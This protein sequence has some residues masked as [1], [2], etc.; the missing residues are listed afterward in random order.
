VLVLTLL[1]AVPLGYAQKQ[2]AQSAIG[3]KSQP[4]ALVV[5]FSNGVDPLHP[6]VQLAS[7]LRTISSESPLQYRFL[8]PGKSQ[9]GL[10]RIILL[11]LSEGVDPVQAALRLHGIAAIEYAEPNYIYHIE[12]IP[13]K[14]DD[15]LYD[16]EWYLRN[17]HVPEAWQI[18]EGDS[19]VHIGFVDTG[20]DWLH[21]DLRNQFAIN[22]A[23]DINHNGYFDAWPSTE[24]RLDPRG[25]SVYGDLDGIDQ[26]GNGFADDVIGYDFVDQGTVNYGDA[27]HRDAIPQD[28]F[29]H[30]TAVAGVLAAEKNNKIGIAGVAPKCKLVAIRAFDFSGNAE[31][32]DV[33]AGIVYAADNH[34]NILNLSFGDPVPSLLQRDAISYATSKSVLVFAS[35]GNDGGDPRHY[36]SD[37]DEVVSVGG[38]TNSP[39]ED[40]V[41]SRTQFGEG[42]DLLAPA[43]N[44][45][46]TWPG[47]SYQVLA[48]TSFSSPIAAAVAGLLW[49][50]RPT[51]TPIELRSILSSATHDV[52]YPGYDHVAANGR[53]DALATLNYKGTAAIKITSPHTDDGFHIGDTIRIK[54]SALSSL[55]QSYSLS[56]GVGANPTR[57]G[58]NQLNDQSVWQSIDSSTNQVLT[59]SLGAWDTHGLKFGVYTLRLAVRSSD[60]RSTEE[61]LTITLADK[62]PTITLFSVDTV[63]L[64]EKRALQVRLTTNQESYLTLYYRPSADG[65]FASKTD[66]RYVHQHVIILTLQEADAGVPLTLQCVAKNLAG[67]SVSVSRDAMILQDMISQRGFAAKRYALPSGYALDSVLALPPGDQVVMSTFDVGNGAGPLKIFQ[68]DGV[69]GK[70][71]LADSGAPG[72]PRSIGNLKHD[73]K[74]NLL[75]Q[76]GQVATVYG[77]NASH[78]LLGD[79]VYQSDPQKYFFSAGL[80]DVDGDG[81]DVIIGVDSD[82]VLRAIKFVGSGFGLIGSLPNTSPPDPQHARNSYSVQSI[83]VGDFLQN[84]K[85]GVAIVDG[86]ADLAAYVRDAGQPAG[87]RQ[88][89]G[90]ENNG[91]EQWTTVS[92]GDFNGDGKIDL[93]FA[94]H[95]DP[96]HGGPFN[97]FEPDFCTLKVYLNQ[98]GGRFT[99]NT[100]ENFLP[101]RDPNSSIY[102]GSMRAIANVTGGKNKM[103]ALSIFP[104]FYLL[105]FDS[106][107][108]KMKAVWQ[109]PLSITTFGAIAH[110]FDRNGKTEFGF[111]AGDSIHFFERDDDYTDR[112]ATPG[113]LDV[114]PRSMSTV[115]L[116]WGVV[117][118]ATRYNVLRA[119]SGRTTFDLIATVTLP[120]FSDTKASNGKTYFYSV[121][122]LDSSKK[123]VE[124]LP[125]FSVLAYVHPTPVIKSV[126]DVHSGLRIKSSEPISQSYVSGGVIV[127]DDS[128]PCSSVIPELDTSM[129]A[130]PGKRLLPGSHH[131]RVTSFELCDAFNSPFDQA[132]IKFTIDTPQSFNTFFIVRWTF[133]NTT[134]IHVTF[135]HIPANDGLGTIHYAITPY[136]RITKIERDPND[137]LSL[138]IDLDPAQPIAPVGTPFVLCIEGVH[139]SQGDLLNK[140]GNCAGET[141]TNKD[142]QQI[143]VFPNPAKTSDDHLTFGGL[144]ATA[145]IT[146]FSE[147]MRVIRQI[148]TAE[149]NGG[150]QWDM[151]DANG[152]PLPSGIYL[153]AVTGMDDNGVTVSSKAAKFVIVSDR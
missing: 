118:G 123:I 142:L 127:I 112:T 152:K 138:F 54:G 59:D 50:A 107:T 96:I 44:I 86:D 48:G 61:H 62:A 72:V 110:D 45:Q 79:V 10:D 119:D 75:A 92:S 85:D 117:R 81:K 121:T 116:S 15:S 70:F 153:Y 136:G 104:N 102:P 57:T 31:D 147:N 37:F 128:I 6:G 111:F 9:F 32:D 83:A 84:G 77:Q 88:I 124:S 25:D 143:F 100:V 133:L 87:F 150:L 64:N 151:K 7:A 69:K 113:G 35:S 108:Q 65:N 73:G 40:L 131:L 19:N 130:T 23:E 21:P 3:H 122:A 27:S 148:Q 11:A 43:E 49:S 78:S 82:E 24:K 91:F 46:T 76:Y 63:Y 93:A 34:V 144:T 141:L 109:Y 126:V 53:I 28:E 29:G 125:A 1:L 68:F 137:T 8:F 17:M 129:V 4:H 55:F 16:A 52:S 103:L 42:M 120:L 140:V 132:T 30:G 71:V 12:S 5:K 22:K 99:V 94:Y 134:R 114:R 33:A 39:S 98:G 18:S 89:F 135:N 74:P 36:P 105:E 101:I 115:D 146:I 80:A 38:T 67:D 58:P 56:Y 90:D 51:L 139:D 97:E 60:L 145:Q 149:K 95:R 2:T 41:W 106:S 13:T 14:P 20:V 26:D 47:G 66:D